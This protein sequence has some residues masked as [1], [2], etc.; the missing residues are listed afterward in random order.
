MHRKVEAFKALLGAGLLALGFMMVERYIVGLVA[1]DR[2]AP[3][4]G[5]KVLLATHVASL[6]SIGVWLWWR[7]RVEA[8]KTDKARSGPR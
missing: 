1:H 7:I 4:A 8:R 6:A 5:V 3:E 2:I